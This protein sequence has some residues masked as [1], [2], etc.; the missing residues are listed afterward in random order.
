MDKII[1]LDSK[2]CN[3]PA[4]FTDL[5]VSNYFR[6]FLRINYHQFKHVYFNGIDPSDFMIFCID[7]INRFNN[8]IDVFS[9]HIDL[10]SFIILVPYWI[11]I[12]ITRQTICHVIIV[13]GNRDHFNNSF[14]IV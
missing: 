6:V 7:L 1:I 8:I 12:S 11:D 2:L 14:F 13:K 9:L 10:D 4:I 3:I 5:I